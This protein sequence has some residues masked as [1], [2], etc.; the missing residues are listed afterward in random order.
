MAEEYLFIEEL[1]TR[2]FN[3]GREF[4]KLED[5]LR[6]FNS[7]NSDSEDYL[8]HSKPALQKLY[9]DYHRMA[10][11]YGI[12]KD[13]L[14]KFTLLYIRYLREEDKKTQPIPTD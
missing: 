11:I 2:V 4:Q 14:K 5:K 7:R 8:E 1:L 9:Q 12:P 13:E 6:D 10:K 3:K